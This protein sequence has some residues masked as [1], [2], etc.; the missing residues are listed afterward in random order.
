MKIQS[1]N[2]NNA[3]SGNA[4]APK[5]LI[6]EI[7]KTAHFEILG[8]QKQHQQGEGEEEEYEEIYFGNGNIPPQFLQNQQMGE[9]GVYDGGE[10]EGDVEEQELDEE[11]LKMLQMH[12]MQNQQMQNQNDPNGNNDMEEYAN[13][14]NEEMEEG[15]G[16][17][18]GEMEV[19]GEEQYIAGEG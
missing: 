14:Q 8:V 9:E 15:D 5:K 1:N 2:A 6:A 17:G 11:Q 10:E 4:A 19:E 12:I 16:E 3:G 7:A 13:Y 18:E